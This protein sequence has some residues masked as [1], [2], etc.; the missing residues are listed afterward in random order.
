MTLEESTAWALEAA[1]AGNPAELARALKARRSAISEAL[2]SGQAPPPQVLANLVDA[3]ERLCGALWA[4]KRELM[5]E[6]ARLQFIQRGFS[7][8]AFA[9]PQ[10]FPK[11]FSLRG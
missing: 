2:A 10:P 7:N 4:R 8:D 1:K 3:G 6:S 11:R 9:A 5:I